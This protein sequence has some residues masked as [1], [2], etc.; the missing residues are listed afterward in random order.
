MNVLRLFRISDSPK[1]VSLMWPVDDISTLSGFKSL[2][3]E[4]R[5]ES[6]VEQR[7][8]SPVDDTLSMEIIECECDF[9]RVELRLVLVE[10]L[11]DAEKRHQI[12]TDHVL[13]H[14]IDFV[15]ALEGIEQ[16]DHVGTVHGGQCIAFIEN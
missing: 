9:S 8:Y 11:L 10:N 3:C 4:R 15:F 12:P 14:E 5:V 7:G 1:S 16:T 6:R 13:H 2:E